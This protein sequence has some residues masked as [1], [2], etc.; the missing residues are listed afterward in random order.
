MDKNLKRKKKFQKN[1]KQA[2]EDDP[3]LKKKIK[4]N[5]KNNEI[6]SGKKENEAIPEEQED[7]IPSQP[8][9]NEYENFLRK[10]KIKKEDLLEKG[11]ASNV[12]KKN[13]SEIMQLL[14]PRINF[15]EK[16]SYNSYERHFSENYKNFSAKILEDGVKEFSKDQ[17]TFDFSKDFSFKNINENNE[18]KNRDEIEILNNNIKIRNFFM[19]KEFKR[20]KTEYCSYHFEKLLLDRNA[21]EFINKEGISQDPILHKKILHIPSEEEFDPEDFEVFSFLNEYIDFIYLGNEE[22]EFLK[23]ILF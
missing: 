20:E 16:I 9:L 5:A 14:I 4:S 19:A 17:K 23:V 11:Y 2:L 18:R 6:D 12:C 7:I 15:I 8:L 1:N 10:Y 21:K 22:N 3:I 13:P